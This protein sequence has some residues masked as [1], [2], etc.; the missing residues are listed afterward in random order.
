[1]FRKE[2]RESRTTTGDCLWGGSCCLRDVPFPALRR[3]AP[4]PAA[5]VAA[6]A[7]AF[8]GR[9]RTSLIDDH[10]PAHQVLAVAI[11]D[12]SLG[13]RIVVDFHESETAGLAREAVTHDGH[14]IDRNSSI[15]K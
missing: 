8:P 1:M 4:R 7:R 3:S 6:A 5:S 14:C 12:C 11:I 10:G 2:A 9:H 13:S 15:G